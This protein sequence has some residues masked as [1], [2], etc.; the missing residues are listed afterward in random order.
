M[1]SR[2]GSCTSR[3][4]GGV[5]LSDLQRYQVVVGAL[6]SEVVARLYSV[7]TNPPEADRYGALKSVITGFF[8]RSRGACFA[9]LDSALYD[10]GR[11]SALPARLSALNRAAGFPWSEEIVRHKLSSLLPQPVRLQLAA[12][13]QALSLEEYSALVDR[14]HP[15]S[16]PLPWP[17]CA[18]SVV[19]PRRTSQPHQRILSLHVLQQQA[20]V[21]ARAHR[22]PL[23][24]AVLSS[25]ESRLASVEASLR[26]LEALLARY[27][28]QTDAERSSGPRIAGPRLLHHLVC[29]LLVAGPPHHPP[30]CESRLGAPLRS[31]LSV[32]GT[33][34]GRPLLRS[35]RKAVP[36]SPH[37][38]HVSSLPSRL[39]PLRRHFRCST[40]NGFLPASAPFSGGRF[41]VDSGTEASVV[42]AADT[43]R[44]T[45][46][47]TA[48]DLLAANRTPI[49]TYGTQTRRVALL[50]GSRFPWA[51]VVADV[52]QAILGMN[53]LAA[54]DPLVDPRRRCLLHQPLA[55]VIHGS[56]ARTRR[57]PSPPSAKRR[58]VAAAQED[59]PDLQALLERPTSLQLVQQQLFDSPWQLWCDVSCG[60]ANPYRTPRSP[61]SR[62]THFLADLRDAAAVFLRTGA[63][64]GPL[65]P[66]YMGPYHVLHG[67]KKYVTL[68][69]KVRPYLPLWDRVK[70]A[71]LPPAPPAAPALLTQQHLPPVVEPF[72][73]PHPREMAPLCPPPRG[74]TAGILVASGPASSSPRRPEPSAPPASPQP[75][76]PTP[77]VS[78]PPSP[79]PVPPLLL[80]SLLFT[81]L[82]PLSLLRASSP[83]LAG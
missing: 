23:L 64:T 63:T 31:L 52:E 22:N 15:H 77:P 46:P 75:P 19:Q 33:P 14:V 65:Q 26:R 36:R 70:E 57:R 41:L 30:I 40:Q 42:P 25:T 72:R 35:P 20:A 47:R 51:F 66:L 38:C 53:I 16:R 78:Q 67:G 81:H 56:P 4:W 50:S 13:P 45:Q 58:T 8:G 48:Y 55:T 32:L 80:Q 83:A 24:A 73:L 76:P 34:T 71:H 11:P 7:L 68:E 54:H 3:L 82:H 62:L 59:D 44:C 1:M 9:A 49:A 37:R 17:A 28:T 74:A 69:I 5:D 21:T 29:S 18:P 6:S 61:P 10:G 60:Q 39:I 43:D 12:A 79:P 27:P 2:P